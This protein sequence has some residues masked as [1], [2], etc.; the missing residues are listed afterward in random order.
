MLEFEWLQSFAVSTAVLILLVSITVTT[1]L[2]FQRGLTINHFTMKS[3]YIIDL[4]LFCKIIE[5]FCILMKPPSSINHPGFDVCLLILE[6][7][8][9]SV[10]LVT[11]L[12]WVLYG[13]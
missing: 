11:V 8:A 5:N 10:V 3:Y 2:K 7:L 13:T 1:K 4:Y 9:C 6:L 12:E